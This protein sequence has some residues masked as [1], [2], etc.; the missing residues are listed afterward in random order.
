MTIDAAPRALVA[1]MDSLA[2][3]TRLRLLL[4]LE[5]AELGV[6]E[7]TDIL[8]LPQSTVSRHLKLLGDRG[9]L[10]SRGQGAANLYA[11]RAA[12]LAPALRRVWPLVREQTEGWATARHDRLRLDRRL[13]EHRNGTQAFF[14][15]SAGRWDRLR[16]EM[17]GHA[18]GDAALRG[19]L[20]RSWVVA[21]LACG[22]GAVTANIAP[23][24]ARVIG[25][26]QSAAM[27]R[28][29]KQRLA[30]HHNVSLRQGTLE[31]LPIQ[32]ASCDAALLVLSLAYLAEPI[33]ALRES[34]RVVKAEGRI[35]VIDLLR[36]DRD[37]FR[38]RMEQ[39]HNGFEIDEM[40]SLL[41][42]AVIRVDHCTPLPPEPGAKGPALILACGSR[43]KTLTVKKRPVA[44]V[45]ESKRRTQ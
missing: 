15:R 28:S 9:W 2:D 32:D 16:R 34:A 1:W 35:V 19:L 31:A 7:M 20:P 30:D 5:R 40:S 43:M 22:T 42:S 14:A 45:D 3:P 41:A 24:V 39:R 29:A 44:T 33:H 6:A 13:A 4:L 12:E 26:D 11:M 38:R 36:H 18:F 17:F 27:L 8:Q 25:V 10:R 21:D 37:D 23:H